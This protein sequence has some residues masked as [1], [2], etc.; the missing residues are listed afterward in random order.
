[1]RCRVKALDGEKIDQ[2]ETMFRERG[3]RLLAR[4]FSPDVQLIFPILPGA[5]VFR[6]KPVL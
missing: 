1:L 2:R 3:D 4:F 6:R 5:Q